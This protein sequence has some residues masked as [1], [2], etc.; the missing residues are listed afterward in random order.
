MRRALSPLVIALAAL[1]ASA[2]QPKLVETL[3][4][5]VVNV[6]VI[7]LDKDGKP[8]TGLTKDDFEI[9]EDRKPQ[10]ITNFYEVRGAEM[11]TNDS[12]PSAPEPAEAPARNFLLFIDV[13][14]LH[15][16][17]RKQILETLGKFVDDQLRSID[18]ASVVT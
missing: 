8:V 2:Q 3:E 9:L 7:V 16:V 10:P 5:R 12:G 14:S 11:R 17:A 15:P 18:L 4:V 13:H 6:E 1:A